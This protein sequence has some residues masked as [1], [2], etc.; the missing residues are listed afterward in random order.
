[1]LKQLFRKFIPD[2]IVNI[3]FHFPLA[4]LAV[5]FYRY[6]ARKLIVIGVTGT[7]GKTTTSTLIY[8]ILKRAR[9]KVALISTVGAK[10]GGLKIPTGFHV[11]SPNSWSLQRLIRKI[12]N[13]NFKYLVLESTSHG[14]VQYRLLGS[15]FYIGI[16]TNITHEHLDYHKTWKNYLLA[17][18]KLFKKVKFS[19]LNKDDFSF[20]PLQRIAAG[21]IITYG[22]KQGDYNLKNFNFKTK[23]IGDYNLSN[24]LGAIA[25]ART[26]GISRKI[27]IRAVAEFKGVEGRMEKVNIGQDFQ[28]FV[29]FAHTPN[30]LKNALEAL[31]KIHHRKIIAVFGCAGLRDKSKRPIMGKI[32]SQLADIIILTAEDPRT[33]NV[34]EIINQISS[35]C[36]KKTI[37]YKEPDR[38]KAINLAINKLARRND[39]I[40]VFGK[41]PEKSM[42]FGKTEY[43]WSD[44]VAVKKAL[45]R[46]MKNGIN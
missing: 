37:V 21:K 24:C 27:I 13:K 10:F 1:M 28:V 19:I 46:R 6:P 3:F 22:L 40:G 42:C 41:G 45:K 34:I 11:T 32:A 23:L 31:N 25:A 30:G 9:K 39:I 12:V 35:G 29:D 36:K 5:L 4:V 17:K 14:L 7:D 44:K 38:Q 16:I 15:N 18:A 20:K 33:E 43:P 8:E 26:L 2:K